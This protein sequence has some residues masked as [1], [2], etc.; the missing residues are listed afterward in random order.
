MSR[1][2]RTVV[3][4]SSLA[5]LGGIGGVIYGVHP[6]W[7]AV[8]TVSGVFGNVFAA[9]ASH[10]QSEDI[11]R[12]FETL[13][14]LI[15]HNSLHD[16]PITVAAT[17]LK[18]S[19]ACKGIGRELAATL[20][21]QP[22]NSNALVMLVVCLAMD[23]SIRQWA[24]GSK[25]LDPFQEIG[26]LRQL[27]VKALNKR[28]SNCALFDAIGILR[29]LEGK[30]D[31]A[32]RWFRRSGKLRSDPFW[33]LLLST[34]YG[35]AGRNAEALREME[36]ACREGASGWFVDFYLGR[37]LLRNGQYDQAASC[38]ISAH[39]TRGNSP[40]LLDSLQEVY[41]RLGR[42]STSAR[43]QFILAAVLLLYTPKR[44]LVY[45]A[46][47]SVHL[48]IAGVCRVSRTLWVISKR[49]KWFAA[50]HAKWLPPEEPHARLGQILA[51]EG[52]YEM[53]KRHLETAAT[54]RPNQAIHLVNLGV[55]YAHLGDYPKAIA[56]CDKALVIDP[57]NLVARYNR[58]R[59]QTGAVGNSTVSS[60]QPGLNAGIRR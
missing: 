60:L 4:L 15:N 10:Q 35:M 27:L 3:V 43:Y 48:L 12:Q 11:K 14:Q 40:Q 13:A 21:R 28:D 8:L 23:L 36:T 53:A 18:R 39:T 9:W 57:D 22:E 17:E 5:I 31:S 1:S 6:I 25:S 32:Q 58:T 56:F 47:A 59:Y 38:L 34:S 20:E 29:D 7:G 37:A 49:I 41:Y 16:F 2:A 42:F 19:G 46:Q 51:T 54:I 52:H 50:V 33:R 26:Q 30:H 44:A 55:C 45:I 24:T